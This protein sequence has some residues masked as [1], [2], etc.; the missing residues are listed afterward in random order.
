MRSDLMPALMVSWLDSSANKR[1][2]AAQIARIQEHIEH[3]QFQAKL[4][5]D[6]AELYIAEA[7][8][9]HATLPPVKVTKPQK[10][11]VDISKQLS[12]IGNIALVA[13]IPVVLFFVLR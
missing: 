4:H 1:A 13:A 5:P 11:M 12:L 10:P 7:N 9:L 2:K 3:L 6:K 8:R